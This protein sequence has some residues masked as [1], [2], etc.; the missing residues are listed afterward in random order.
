M[1]KSREEPHERKRRRHEVSE[2]RHGPDQGKGKKRSK[3][4]KGKKNAEFVTDIVQEDE[5]TQKTVK[6]INKINKQDG[7]VEKKRKSEGGKKRK[8]EKNA[9]AE[10]ESEKEGVS[11]SNSLSAPTSFLLSTVSV[12]QQL[13]FFCKQF[14]Y[15]NKF[16][17][18]SLELEPVK[19]KILSVF[20]FHSVFH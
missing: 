13:H 7:A 9:G 3:S 18:S 19:G 17:I 8:R 5:T 1:A 10:R 4:L 14:E 15:S 6:A 16:K 11:E 20:L 12:D 2:K